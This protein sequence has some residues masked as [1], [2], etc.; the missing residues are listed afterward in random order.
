MPWATPLS[1]TGGGDEWQLST[2][3]DRVSPAARR[4]DRSCRIR[5]STRTER[6]GQ[7]SDRNRTS[8]AAIC[9]SSLCGLDIAAA[10]LTWLRQGRH[11]HDCAGQLPFG[12]RSMSRFAGST[13]SLPRA[14]RG[15]NV[16]PLRRALARRKPRTASH[17][18]TA[19]YP[20]VMA[21]CGVDALPIFLP[22]LQFSSIPTSRLASP[23]PRATRAAGSR[24]LGRWST[25]S[26]PPR[27]SAG[28]RD[29]ACRSPDPDRAAR[30][31]AQG[32]AGPADAPGADRGRGDRPDGVRLSRRRAARL[33]PPR[34][35]QGRRAAARADAR[36]AV[37]QGLSGDHL[38]PAD[39]QRALP[40]H[41]PAR[42]QEPG[43]GG[44]KL[45]RAV[46]A[47]PEPRPARGREARRPLARAAGCCSSICPRA[48]RGASGCT[49]GS[50]IPTGR[51]SRSSAG[52]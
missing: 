33:C 26:L 35:G 40:G 45:F 25:R 10:V 44:A 38:R 21:G 36:G 11:C 37:R 49:R 28:H 24:G 47:D 48:K 3:A 12:M 43:R 23:F 16:T 19:G 50:T 32:A 34:Q 52:R 41:R 42:G 29:A 20:L 31:A 39:G 9:A 5:R 15:S 1:R 22:C 27:L 8:S 7:P 46:R 13:A 14:H 6:L 17:A 2:K 51:T 18:P 4:W 30:L